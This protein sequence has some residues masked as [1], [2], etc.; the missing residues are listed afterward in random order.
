M[1]VSAVVSAAFTQRIGY[2]V[3]AMLACPCV[4]A[5]GEGLLSTFTPTIGSSH[6]IAYQ[7]LVGF[8]L[9][10]GMQTVGLA[11]Q[12]VLPKEDVPTGLAINFFTQQLGGAIFVSAGQTIL[13]SLLVKRLSGVPG[14]D[15][16]IIVNTGATDLHKVVPEQYMGK[17]VDAYNYATTRIFLAAVA[18]SC[19]QLACAL[20]VEWRSIK[21]GRQG[22]PPAKPKAE[23]QAQP[24][25]KSETE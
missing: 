5:T 7:F 25:Q 4:M 18:L 11:V 10:L 15:P 9:G 12:T 19:A 6:W 16:E 8:G 3:P 14:L 17:V 1:V 21:K 20:F 23:Q 2:Y 24:E 22:P 13:S